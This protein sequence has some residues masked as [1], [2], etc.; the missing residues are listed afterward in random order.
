M[1]LPAPAYLTARRFH[2]KFSYPAVPGI[3]LP[4]TR[5]IPGLELRSTKTATT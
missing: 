4:G 1:N 5:E 2:G 3:T